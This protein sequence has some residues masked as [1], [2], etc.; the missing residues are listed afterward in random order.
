MLIVIIWV[1]V[2]LP[3]DRITITIAQ[4]LQLFLGS[5]K[6]SRRRIIDLYDVFGPKSELIHSFVAPCVEYI[7]SCNNLRAQLLNMYA[8]VLK[9]QQLMFQYFGNKLVLLIC[10]WIFEE[11]QTL[12]GSEENWLLELINFKGEGLATN[13]KDEIDISNSDLEDPQNAEIF[14]LHS[15]DTI[16]NLAN[17]QYHQDLF[18]KQVDVSFNR[19]A[20]NSIYNLSHGVVEGLV[21]LVSPQFYIPHHEYEDLWIC[22]PIFYPIVKYF[23]LPTDQKIKMTGFVGCYNILHEVENK[24]LKLSCVQDTIASWRQDPKYQFSLCI[25]VFDQLIFGCY[26]F[27]WFVLYCQN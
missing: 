9:H 25:F 7:Q 3:F 13:A 15:S 11:G 2:L 23:P 12:F 16:N 19:N 20:P 8:H 22:G 26:L 24:L 10:Q 27:C 17:D 18:A 1:L 5:Q 14:W 6:L 4:Q 21:L